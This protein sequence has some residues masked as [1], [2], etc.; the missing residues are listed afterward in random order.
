MAEALRALEVM[1]ITV[2][3]PVE[4]RERNWLSEKNTTE[5]VHIPN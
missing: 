4:S 3:I 1:K 2:F 5:Q